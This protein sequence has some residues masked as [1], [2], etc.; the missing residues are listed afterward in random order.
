MT[1]MLLSFFRL[2]GLLCGRVGTAETCIG[3]GL[4]GRTVLQVHIPC[5][6]VAAVMIESRGLGV[7]VFAW[8]KHGQVPALAR[9]D[10][11]HPESDPLTSSAHV[12][13]NLGSIILPGLAKHRLPSIHMMEAGLGWLTNAVEVGHLQS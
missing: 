2:A 10:W 13:V 8:E 1:R 12:T 5:V 11:R 3:M 6:T 9:G 4:T 7:C